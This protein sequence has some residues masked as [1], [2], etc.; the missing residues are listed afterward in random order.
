MKAKDHSLKYVTLLAFTLAI[1]S[2]ESP[3]GGGAA[4]SGAY[5]GSSFGDPWYYGGYYGDDDVIVVPPD[6]VDI[7]AHPENPIALPPDRGPRPMPQPSIPSMPRA[8]FRR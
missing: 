3:D 8:S 4:S 5:Y 1:V 2:C 7:G 6:R